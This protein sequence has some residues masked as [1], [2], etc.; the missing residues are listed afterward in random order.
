MYILTHMLETDKSTI[1]IFQNK[2]SV[3]MQ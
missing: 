1:K 3:Y 2:Y